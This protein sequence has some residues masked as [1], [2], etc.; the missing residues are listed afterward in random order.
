MLTII[1]TLTLPCANGLRI[2]GTSEDV[3]GNTTLKLKFAE[4]T[5]KAFSIPLSMLPLTRAVFR[6]CISLFLANV[7]EEVP[8]DMLL[9]ISKEVKAYI[10]A[11]GTAYHKALLNEPQT[12]NQR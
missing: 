1:P 5:T 8:L 3:Y 12:Q 6:Q 11:N 10:V 7:V 9:E 2:V 4:Q